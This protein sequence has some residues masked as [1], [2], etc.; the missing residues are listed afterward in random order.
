MK[1]VINIKNYWKI[2]IFYNIYFGK[3]K[4]GFTK[5]FMDERLSVIGITKNLTKEEFLN[6]LVH[7]AKHVQSH[8]C[9][10][11]NISE[12]SEDAA[13]LIGYLVMKMYA[14]AKRF[15]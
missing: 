14:V 10:Y 6:T 8:I 13:Y 11:Y 2:V 9:R 15:L 1:Q 3:G 7:E 12:D 4:L 5:T